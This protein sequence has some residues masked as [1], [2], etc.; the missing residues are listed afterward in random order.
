MPEE[1]VP[2]AN[3]TGMENLEVEPL[4]DE[5]LESVPG[6]NTFSLN[7]QFQDCSCGSTGG[8]CTS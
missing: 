6:G 3:T 7:D 4:S 5:D 2:Q 8:N 1:K